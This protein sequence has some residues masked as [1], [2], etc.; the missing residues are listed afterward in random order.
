MI[1]RFPVRGY[2]LRVILFAGWMVVLVLTS[3]GFTV[4]VVWYSKRTTSV[5]VE[6]DFRVRQIGLAL[7][8]ILLSME[9]NRKKF[10]LLKKEEY[11]DRF[12]EDLGRLGTSLEELE[13]LGLTEA[14]RSCWVRLRSFWEGLHAEAPLGELRMGEGT[15]SSAETPLDEVHRL[16]GIN[17]ESMKARITEMG[18]LE[19]ETIRLGMLWG[20]LSVVV[21]GGLSFFLVRS[22]TVPIGLL[23]Q[24]TREIAQGK[25]GH[26]IDLSSPDELGELAEAFNEM[27]ERLQHLDDMKADFMAI[28]S[29]ELKTPLTSMKEAVELLREGAAGPLNPKQSHLLDINAQGIQKLANLVDEILNLTRM[30]AGMLDLIRTWTDFGR[31]VEERVV[32]F[33]L[34][35]EK[36]RVTLHLSVRPNPLPLI[37]ADAERLKQVLDNLLDNAIRFTPAGGTVSIAVEYREKGLPGHRPRENGGGRTSG[38]GL[39]C[40]ISDTGE[41]IPP[42]ERKRVFEKF[43]QIRRKSS[44]GSGSGLGLSIAKHIIEGHGGAIWVEDAVPQGG[45]SFVFTVPCGHAD[46]MSASRV[47]TGVRTNRE[48]KVRGEGETVRLERS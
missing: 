19:G 1:L 31:L 45:A 17:Q 7:V 39:L 27:A 21:A 41:G 29:H 15:Q 24:G 34:L 36:K 13:G 28:V 32:S 9:R 4:G 42:A 37:H 44:R 10:L 35:A 33:R 2:R 8:D 26:R 23:R 12:F 47:E 5:L 46:R 48:P 22:V 25:F 30:E 3:I 43:Y 20:G 18:H 40:R 16:L 6:R 11:K 38:A 14:E